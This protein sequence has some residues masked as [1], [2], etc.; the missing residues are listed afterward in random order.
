MAY[1]GTLLRGITDGTSSSSSIDPA[2][3]DLV[4]LDQPLALIPA[5]SDWALPGHVEHLVT[6]PD[7]FARIP[8][9]VHAP[10]PSSASSA[11]TPAASG[12]PARG[13]RRTDALLHVDAVVEVSEVR[14]IVN[15]RP[16]EGPVVTEARAHGFEHRAHRSRSASGSSCRSWWAEAAKRTP[17]PTCG[18]TGSR[19]P[20]RRRGGVAERHG[21]SMN[22][23]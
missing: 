17:R 3:V 13:R 5:L 19:C 7:F 16:V 20:C 4:F 21:C 15:P 6:R 1:A 10:R 12:R 18:N 11:D 9:A 22:S 8:V 14:Q 2:P 23:P